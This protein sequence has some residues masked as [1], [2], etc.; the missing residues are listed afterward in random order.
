[1][2]T[3]FYGILFVTRDDGKVSVYRKARNF[4]AYELLGILEEAQ[5]DILRQ[6]KGEIR[7]EIIKR[8]AIKQESPDERK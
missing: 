5:I 7:P 2:K 6:M 3:Q 4:N 8:V 1:M